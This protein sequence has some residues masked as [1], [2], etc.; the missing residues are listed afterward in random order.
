MPTGWLLGQQVR[1]RGARTPTIIKSGEGNH[2]LIYLGGLDKG[3]I[4]LSGNGTGGRHE[5][6]PDGG[7]RVYLR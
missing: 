1:K 6:L 2:F 3:C 5:H 4:P 7:Q